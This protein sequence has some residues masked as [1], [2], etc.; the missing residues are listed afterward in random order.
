MRVLISGGGTGGHIYPALAIIEEIKKHKPNAEF[1]YIGTEKGL[2]KKIV[3][4]AGIKID[5]IKIFGFQRKISLQN[6]KNIFYLMHSILMAQKI[7]KSFKP[8]IAIGTGGYVCGPVLLA[9][10]MLKIPTLIH[11]QNVLPGLTNRLLARIVDKVAISFNGSKEYFPENKVILTGNPRATTVSNAKK[12]KGLEFLQV[13]KDNRIVLIVGGSRGAKPINDVFIQAINRLEEFNNVHFVFVTGDGEYQR[14]KQELVNLKLP[15]NLT[16][17]PFLYNLPDVLAATDLVINRA[18]ASTLAEI[19][20]LKI[21]AILVPS[22]YV[23]DNHQEIN[24][25]WLE[26]QGAIV[27]ILQQNLTASKLIDEIKSIIT[28]REKMKKLKENAEKLAVIDAANK[29]Y[30]IICDLTKEGGSC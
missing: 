5:Y 18:G 26:D 20:A 9:A 19:T 8:D 22:P 14:V 17:Y 10:K 11:E 30:Q 24:A 3:P 23:T 15:N 12:E 25:R 13:D 16:I 28:N 29:I 27:M 6:A 2:E 1:L 7:I 21:P 4:Q